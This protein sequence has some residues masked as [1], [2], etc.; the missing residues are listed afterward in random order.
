MHIDTT[1]FSAEE[2]AERVIAHFGIP[3]TAASGKGGD[4]D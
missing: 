3:T 1:D 4:G 2:V